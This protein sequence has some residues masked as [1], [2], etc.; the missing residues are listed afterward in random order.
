MEPALLTYLCKKSVT[1]KN[2]FA[3]AA[4]VAILKQFILTS[5]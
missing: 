2:A 4:N 3:H 1:F 5:V